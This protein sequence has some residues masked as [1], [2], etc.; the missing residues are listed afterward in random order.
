MF[1]E[2]HLYKTLTCNKDIFKNALSLRKEKKMF[3]NASFR[4][5]ILISL[6]VNIF[7]KSGLKYDVSVWLMIRIRRSKQKKKN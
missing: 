1:W 3:L 5:Y 6:N 2:M 4:S 7:A